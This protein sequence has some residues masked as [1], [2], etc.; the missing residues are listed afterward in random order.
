VVR[1]AVLALCVAGGAGVLV[2]VVLWI[3][4]PAQKDDTGVAPTLAGQRS[5][6]LDDAAALVV[7]VGILLVLRG[8]GIW[9]GDAFAFVGVVAAVGLVLVWGRGEGIDALLGGRTAAM[10]IAV[11]AVLVLAG[12]TAFVVGTSG[13]ADVGRTFLAAAVAAVGVAVLAGPRL[14]RMA[15][16]LSDERRARIRSEERAEIAAHLHD[17][18]LQTLTLIQQRAGDERAV[19]GL[20]RRQE[21]E[22][23]SWLFGAPAAGDTV[24]SEVLARDLAGVEDDFAVAVE[25]VAVGD[26]PLDDPARVLVAA[27]HEATTNAARHSGAGKVDVYV[28]VEAERLTGYVRD[29]GRGFVPDAVPADRRGL[30]DSVIGRVR[31]A[32]GQATVRSTVGEGTEVALEVP[33]RQP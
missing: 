27:V 14:R 23:R 6:R 28:E 16:E 19:V 9:F 30:A 7:V 22:L 2:Y 21:R 32:G 31:R 26:S 20:A 24:L 13:L 17:G 15:V 4:M 12:F 10:R 5:H 3:V 25:L 1:L 8:A 18:V 11:G 29:R 33:R